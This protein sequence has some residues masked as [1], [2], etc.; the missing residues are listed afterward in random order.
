MELEKEKQ[1]KTKERGRKEI[2]EISTE[3]DK[4]ESKISYK[5]SKS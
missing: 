5:Y 2:I 4:T 3:T 1:N